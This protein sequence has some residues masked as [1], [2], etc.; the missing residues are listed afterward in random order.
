MSWAFNRNKKYSP[1]LR[2]RAVRTSCRRRRSRDQTSP[3]LLPA[4]PSLTVCTASPG[5]VQPTVK[6]D[7]TVNGTPVFY[8]YISQLSRGFHLVVGIV[9]LSPSFPV[10]SRGHVDTDSYILVYSTLHVR[11]WSAQGHKCLYNLINRCHENQCLCHSLWLITSVNLEDYIQIIF[12][13]SRCL[14]PD[15]LSAE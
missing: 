6:P 5:S 2:E 13:H 3:A 1:S 9:S 7:S 14:T 10:A 15:V 12:T 4:W 11:P 8:G